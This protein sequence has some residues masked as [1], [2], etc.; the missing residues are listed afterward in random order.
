MTMLT[1]KEIAEQLGIR[2]DTFRK[3][4]ESRP[5]FPKPALKLSQKMV[6]WNEIDVARWRRR[7]EA[8][9]QA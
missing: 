2:A 7:Q 6:L 5:D 1:R 3:S 8:L 9:A 4:V